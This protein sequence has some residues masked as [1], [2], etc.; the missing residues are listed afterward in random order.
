MPQDAVHLVLGFEG[1]RTPPNTP[2]PM[3]TRLALHRAAA[4]QRLSKTGLLTPHPYTAAL[5]IVSSSAIFRTV[6]RRRLTS[7]AKCQTPR[8]TVPKRRLSF[9]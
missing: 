2:D 4:A 1:H 7:P 6:H 5:L 8:L 9:S 3:A